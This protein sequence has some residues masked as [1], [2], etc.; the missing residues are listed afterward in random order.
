MK[1]IAACEVRGRN[2]SD[3][4]LKAALSEHL[5]NP[6]RR[7]D[8]L[9]LLALLAA[10]PLKAHMQA[11]SGLYLAATWP[12]RQNMFA[13]LESVCAQQKLPKPFEFVNSVSN[14][15]GFHV[16]QQLGLQGPNLFIGAGP[17]VWGHLLDLA[18][19]DLERAQ[20][21]QGLVMLVEEDLQDGFSIQ[22]LVLEPG[23][24]SLRGRDFASLS[25]T[26]EVLRLE[27]DAE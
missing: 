23:G 18:G 17:Q 20:I 3:S 19:N 16:A 5:D 12:A 10:A 25:A 14:A 13:L 7:T 26:V 1:V 4:Q 24:D 2:R 27:L 15:A 6:P 11:D 21:R 22:A 8:R 9:T